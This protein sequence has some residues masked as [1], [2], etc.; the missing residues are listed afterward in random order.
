MH[1]LKS[2][3][4]ISCQPTPQPYHLIVSTE[5]QY[6]VFLSYRSKEKA[7]VRTVA[8]RLRADR[9]KVWFDEWVRGDN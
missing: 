3:L 9:L 4:R 6:D 1:C 7:V 5:F 2:W 8:E